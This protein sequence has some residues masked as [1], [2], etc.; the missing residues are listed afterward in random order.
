MKFTAR[1]D[2]EAPIGKVWAVV[3]D[4]DSFELAALR[5]GVEVARQ[6]TP[7]AP[8]WQVAFTFRGK[9][10][11]IALQLDRAEEPGLLAFAAEG[12]M[13]QG[14]LVMELVE[15]G[16]RRTRMTVTAELRPLTLA[17]R[18]FLQSVKLARGRV[19]RRYQQG[20]A[21]LAATIEARTRGQT[22]GF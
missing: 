5:R 9:R 7:A 19:T 22:A 1:E 20:V 17:A 12:R 10:R 18:L 8:A 6:G 16:P 3:T 14:D 21:K 13:L 4:Y 15:L 11:Q 2:I